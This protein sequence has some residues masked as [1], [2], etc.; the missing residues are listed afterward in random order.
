MHKVPVR[1]VLRQIKNVR[2]SVFCN[3]ITT[4][5]AFDLSKYM[6]QEFKIKFEQDYT[7]N[8]SALLFESEKHFTWFLLKWS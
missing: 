2:D 3:E 7:G 1:D 5:S 6:E 4:T 8:I